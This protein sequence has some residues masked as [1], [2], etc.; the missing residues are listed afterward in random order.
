MEIDKN[1]LLN[2]LVERTNLKLNELNAQVL[3]L[4]SQLQIAIEI[5]KTLQEQLD[6]TKKKESKSDY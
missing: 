1:K 5:N 4:E 3:M 2:T 6:K